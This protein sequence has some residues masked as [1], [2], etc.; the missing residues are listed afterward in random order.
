MLVDIGMRM[1]SPREL[2]N[3]QGFRRDYV[4]LGTQGEQ[5]AR[6]GNSVPPQ[7]AAAVI[8]ANMPRLY[9]EAAE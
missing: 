7:L 1:L 6:V 9:A 2:S 4:L 3:C 8:G 5:I